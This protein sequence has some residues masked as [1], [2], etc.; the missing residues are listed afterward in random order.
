MTLQVKSLHFLKTS[1][2][3]HPLLQHHI[4]EENNPKPHCCAN[5][6]YSVA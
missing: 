1:E 2:P 6:K 4:A 5:R 3:L